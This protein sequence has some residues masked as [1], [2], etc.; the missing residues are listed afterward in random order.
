MNYLV[1]MHT[2]QT[3]QYLFSVPFDSLDIEWPILM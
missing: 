2:L 3:Q 1:I